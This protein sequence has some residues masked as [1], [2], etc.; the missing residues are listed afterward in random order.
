MIDLISKRVTSLPVHDALL[1][2]CSQIEV[3][4]KVMLDNFE[5]MGGVTGKIVAAIAACTAV[6][7]TIVMFRYNS[8]DGNGK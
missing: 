1:V 3:A 6:A 2:P 7:S 8:D 4:R 5:S